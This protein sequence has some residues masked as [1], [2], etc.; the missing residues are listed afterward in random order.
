MA[1]YELEGS[2]T[3][4]KCLVGVARPTGFEPVAF[5]SG[6]RRSIQL[7]YGRLGQSRLVIVVENR[8]TCYGVRR[9]M[10]VC[11]WSLKLAVISN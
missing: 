9:I 7:S 2:V 10:T 4:Q 3:P 5:G 8:A 11:V 6:G 1:D